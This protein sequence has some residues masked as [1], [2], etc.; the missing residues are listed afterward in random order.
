MEAG[1]LSSA[2]WA[3][4]LES[5][6][7]QCSSSELKATSQRPRRVGS[8]DGFQRQSAEEFPLSYEDFYSIQAFNC[9]NEDH[10]HYGGQSAYS[11][12]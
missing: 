6:E 2:L 9:L 10:P 1:K 4:R 8:A 12:R 5:Q 11:G 3:G 7:S